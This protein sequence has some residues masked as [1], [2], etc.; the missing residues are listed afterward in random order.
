MI[1]CVSNLVIKISCFCFHL[2]LF[3]DFCSIYFFVVPILK[4]R[5]GTIAMRYVLLYLTG[6]IIS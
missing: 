6:T 5:T 3:F 4:L 1:E 2:V